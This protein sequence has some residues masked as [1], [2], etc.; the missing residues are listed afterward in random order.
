M[1]LTGLRDTQRADNY[2]LD[3]YFNFPVPLL[4]YVQLQTFLILIVNSFSTILDAIKD[5]FYILMAKLFK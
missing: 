1:P 2:H 3:I 4:V 5:P